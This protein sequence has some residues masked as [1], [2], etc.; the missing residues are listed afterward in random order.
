MFSQLFPFALLPLAALA[1]PAPEQPS[2]HDLFCFRKEPDLSN[3]RPDGTATNQICDTLSSG[4]QVSNGHSICRLKDYDVKWFK[5]R[6]ESHVDENAPKGT[7][8]IAGTTIVTP[9]EFDLYCFGHLS[10]YGQGP[11]SNTRNKLNIQATKDVCATLSSGKY[12]D[13]PT[14]RSCRVASYDVQ[15]FTERC[16]AYKREFHYFVAGTDLDPVIDLSMGPETL[17]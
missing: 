6:C 14:K 2:Q 9:L 15:W 16:A 17:P 11:H 3:F 12:Q 1:A 5:E 10:E 7:K 13:E 8:F 4:I